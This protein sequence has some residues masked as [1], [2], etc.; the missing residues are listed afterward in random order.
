MRTERSS[1]SSQCYVLFNGAGRTDDGAEPWVPENRG[2][3]GFIAAPTRIPSAMSASECQA[4]TRLAANSPIVAAGL[5]RPIEGYREGA[6]R[7]VTY[8][9]ETAW[10]YRRVAELFTIANE[11]YRYRIVAMAEPLLYCEYPSDGK[12]DWHVDCGEPPTGSRKISLSVQLSDSD[13][14]G[15]GR[16]EFAPNGELRDARAMGTAIAFPSFAWHRVTP[17]TTGVRRSLVAWAH[18]PTFS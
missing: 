9:N 4:V 2:R 10:L 18:G 8:G 6:A 3:S 16:L 13:D 12:F 7:E 11:W 1:A 17:V 14:Y 5:I 15:E